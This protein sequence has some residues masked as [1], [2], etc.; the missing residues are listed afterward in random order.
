MRLFLI[1]S[2]IFLFSSVNAYSE[3]DALPEVEAAASI[4]PAL[5]KTQ[6]SEN[7]FD[8]ASEEDLKESQRFLKYCTQNE[9]LNKQKDCKCAA[10]A[11]LETRLKLGSE[12]SPEEIIAD[13]RNSCLHDPKT[14]ITD[15]DVVNLNKYSEKQIEEAEAVYEYCQN[16][17]RFNT[18]F[19]CECFASKFL[20]ERYKKG[21]L[22]PKNSIFVELQPF[23]KNVVN[24]TGYEY[25]TCMT[26]PAIRNTNGIEIKKFCE[27]YARQWAKNYEGYNGIIDKNSRQHLK[28]VS[29]AYCRRPDNYK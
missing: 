26:G 14:A 18:A 20:E 4:D 25:S 1:F 11:Y 27:C 3:D 15:E 24:S 17:V 9:T 22:Y 6:A 13:T 2:L 29:R 23:C 8:Q 7:I 10:V 28:S 19:D 16:T 21:P 12:A 5:E